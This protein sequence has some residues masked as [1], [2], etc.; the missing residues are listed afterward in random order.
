M[1]DSY[2]ERYQLLAPETGEQ[3]PNFLF[4]VCD[5]YDYGKV[6]IMLDE[7]TEDTF[8]QYIEPPFIED[9]DSGPFTAWFW[10]H[11]SHSAAKPYGIGEHSLLRR[12]GYVMLDYDR[13]QRRYNL[14]VPPD[15]IELHIDPTTE[16]VRQ[17]NQRSEKLKQ[18]YL[19]RS[20]IYDAGGRGYWS[21]DDDSKL[22]WNVS[23]PGHGMENILDSR[24]EHYRDYWRGK[25]LVDRLRFD[26]YFHNH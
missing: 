6:S 19:K 18:S 10:V 15:P 16:A 7:L 22:I 8:N 3:D 24:V 25:I 23:A 1:A 20:Q 14:E 4:G 26:D 17:S 11:K 5:V 2:D 13:L 12:E 9:P 21:N